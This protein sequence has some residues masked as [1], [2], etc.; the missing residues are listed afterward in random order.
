M[1]LGDDSD[2]QTRYRILR[3]TA[4]NSQFH[5]H[6][7]LE[8]RTGRAVMVHIAES[9][10]PE[11]AD[12]IREQVGKLAP[13]DA[14]HI[15]EVTEL[16]TGLAV[17]T[18]FI[19]GLTFFSEW[20]ADK[21]RSAGASVT[22][23]FRGPGAQS[24]EPD[25][26]ATV[27][28]QAPVIPPKAT[29][30]PPSPPAPAAETVVR[31][32][33]KVSTPPA[34]PTVIP[35]A[36]AAPTVPPPTVVPPTVVP[37]TVV[38]PAALPP[39]QATPPAASSPRSE[40]GEY[41][42]I[43]K[44]G[45]TPA[46]GT[47]A[48]PPASP[49]PSFNQAAPP[50]P[51]AQST[52]QPPAR[53]ELPASHIPEATPGEYTR[54]FGAQHASADRTP[55]P[56]PLNPPPSDFGVKPPASSPPGGG[57]RSATGAFG[58]WGEPTPP[59]GSAFGQPDSHS[60]AKSPFSPLPPMPA[61]AVPPSL[62]PTPALPASPPLPSAPPLHRTPGAPSVP[63]SP[64]TDSNP[65]AGLSPFVQGGMAGVPP[66]RA[67][68]PLSN[69]PIDSP[70]R[71]TPPSVPLSPIASAGFGA[72]LPPLQGL[73]ASLDSPFAKPPAPKQP[74]GY[75]QIQA[76]ITPAPP[77]TVPS[78][79]KAVAPKRQGAPL[80]TALILVIAVVVILAITLI[81]YFALRPPAR[82]AVA[83]QSTATP[84]ATAPQKSP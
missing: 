33:V 49:T 34:A 69:D 53:Q 68:P 61:S 25:L 31:P 81:L 82:P 18:E 54:I 58:A 63:S 70:K 29:P 83:P 84:A 45:G 20:L 14:R 30:A 39:Q 73:G 2:F 55:R 10:S 32:A 76:S 40:P 26:A 17:V 3:S 4:S 11:T 60:A 8:Q 16:P 59:A 43:F 23:Q 12:R 22:D 64:F 6:A 74:G 62:P 46:T 37:P 38:P 1:P 57:G 27:I 28:I 80:P 77:P 75:T 41:T 66:V 24:A 72:S 51:P 5:S 13:S 56:S 36:A 9:A 50:P 71:P 21:S 48:Q 44:M 52:P 15:L 35:P 42:R 67:T 47:P 7:A 65:S 78:P 19:Q 79:E